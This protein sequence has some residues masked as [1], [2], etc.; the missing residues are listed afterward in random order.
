[1]VKKEDKSSGS[2]TMKDRKP[3]KESYL[4][5]CCSLSSLFRFL[6]IIT[7]QYIHSDLSS[8]S[9]CIKCLQ[10]VYT[11]IFTGLLGL[12]VNISPL[13]VFL[14]DWI[15]CPME[16]YDMCFIFEFHSDDP[17]NTKV[18]VIVMRSNEGDYINYTVTRQAVQP[19]DDLA[20]FTF[21]FILVSGALSYAIFCFPLIHHYICCKDKKL[22]HPF[23]DSTKSTTDDTDPHITT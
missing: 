2:N 12:A 17:N 5:K 11:I 14:Y 3:A 23:H 20:K 8:S 18:P 21:L 4:R 7:F 19:F 6:S 16:Y 13:A 1:M 9:S 10:I 22:F 15:A